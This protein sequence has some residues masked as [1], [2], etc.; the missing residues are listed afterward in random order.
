MGWAATVL[1]M[2]IPLGSAGLAN[3]QTT[4]PSETVPRTEYE[5]LRRDMDEQRR[6]LEALEQANSTRTDVQKDAAARDNLGITTDIR[7]SATPN[8][9][10]P[11]VTEGPAYRVDDQSLRLAH[12]DGFDLYMGLAAV[13][14]FQWLE[15]KDVAINGVEQP[16]LDP[17]FQTP[18]GDMSFLADFDHGKMEVYFDLY[19]SSRPHPSQMYGNEGYILMRGL[20]DN[21]PASE[22]LNN[23]LFKYVNVKAGDFEIDYGDHRFHRSDNAWVQRNRLIGNSIVD[24]DVEEI[25]VEVYSKPSYVNWLV[26]A[27][28]GTTSENFN[29]GRGIAAVHGKL[30][31]D[32]TD[33]LRTSLSAYYVDHSDNPSNTA[34]GGTKGALFTGQRSGGAYGAVFSKGDGPGQVEPGADKNVTAVQ[35]DVTWLPR[36]WE[37]YGN[38]GWMQDQDT[39][40]S[41]P[42]SPRDSWIYGTGEVAYFFT[43]RIYAAGRYSFA[44]ADEL[45]DANSDGIA[46]RFQ[47]GGGYWVTKNILAKMEGVYQTFDSFNG[48][49]EVSGVDAGDDP[50]FY[51]VVFEVSFQF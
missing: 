12:G 4:A 22:F 40:G 6:R 7:P 48:G 19:I 29:E 27:T 25:G 46:H 36:P 17:S 31:K 33:Q 28:S 3:A 32:W 43:P 47:L 37:L 38:V 21:A 13:G 16:D 5:Q 26:G 44:M 23:T 15:Q 1:G 8:W 24:P 34:Q 49:D 18:W 20:P 39:N 42:G 50:N 51:G 41:D 45:A 9:E 14:R 2:A 35:G 11:L 30:W 10:Q